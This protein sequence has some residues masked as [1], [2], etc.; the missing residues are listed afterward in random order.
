[1]LAAQPTAVGL[2]HGE[3]DSLTNKYQVHEALAIAGNRLDELL[4]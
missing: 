2:Q 3:N 4:P 1:L